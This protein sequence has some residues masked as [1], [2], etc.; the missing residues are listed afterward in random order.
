VQPQDGVDLTLRA[1]RPGHVRLSVLDGNGV[2]L[3]GARVN[4]KAVPDYLGAGYLTML[5]STPPTGTD[6]ATTVSSLAPGAYELTVTS[7]SK[8][9]TQAVT[10]AEGAEVVT[11]VTLP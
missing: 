8:R 1:P 5:D 3:P 6:G 11:T 10:L 2:P 4:C 9:A 7:G